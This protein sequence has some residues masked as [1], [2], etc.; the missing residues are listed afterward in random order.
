MIMTNIEE[1]L[2]QERNNRLA[3]LI[4]HHPLVVHI[5]VTLVLANALLVITTSLLHAR[6]HLIVLFLNHVMTATAVALTEV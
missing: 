2:F 5:N 4:I 3:Q 1:N 6:N